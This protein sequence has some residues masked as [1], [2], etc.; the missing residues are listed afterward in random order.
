ML[1]SRITPAHL[2]AVI[3]LVLALAG[4]A[5]ALPGK[6]SV[7]RNDLAKNSVRSKQ[8]KKDSLKGSDI[9]EG[10]LTI[11]ESAAPPAPSEVIWIKVDQSASGPSIAAASDPGFSVAEEGPGFGLTR[12]TAPQPVAACGA[13]VSPVLQTSLNPDTASPSGLL[14]EVA[15]F[16]NFPNI[17]EI[18]TGT[19]DGGGV[20]A[21]YTVVIY[22]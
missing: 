9:D 19:D 7:D 16:E 6:N 15:L 2:V 21:D 8:V 5:I 13:T 1:T 20:N 11:P 3:A 4:T 14:S 10:S 18:A 12:I 22:C 17:L